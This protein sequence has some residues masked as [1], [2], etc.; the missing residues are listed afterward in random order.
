VLRG[1]A[2]QPVTGRHIEAFGRFCHFGLHWRKL[3]YVAR[4]QLEFVAA[5]EIDHCRQDRSQAVSFSGQFQ[6]N[7]FESRQLPFSCFQKHLINP[8]KFQN[9]GDLDENVILIQ[10]LNLA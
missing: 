10:Q 1:V 9:N 6:L 3:R 8:L 7:A 2:L 4:S 5:S